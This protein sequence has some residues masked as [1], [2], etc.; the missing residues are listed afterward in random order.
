M[1]LFDVVC[2]SITYKEKGKTQIE[3][4]TTYINLPGC[5]LASRIKELKSDNAKILKVLTGDPIVWDK[6]ESYKSS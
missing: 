1:G 4:G 2:Y 5:V 6:I 3:T